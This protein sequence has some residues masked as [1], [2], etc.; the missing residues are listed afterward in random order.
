MKQI[1]D[2]LY[3]G[4][5]L[6]AAAIVQLARSTGM[7]LREAILAGLPRLC[8]EASERAERFARTAQTD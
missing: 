4:G 6:R 8:R 2:A 5:Q 1:V 3:C 7:R